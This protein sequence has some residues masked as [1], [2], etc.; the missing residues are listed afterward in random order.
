M[1]TLPKIPE[2]NH[3]AETLNR[4]LVETVCSM[5]I[6]SKLPHKFWAEALTT[7]AYLWNQSPTK[8]IEGISP[9]KAWTKEKPQ[10]EH[11]RAFGCNAYSHVPKDERQKLHSKVRKCIFWVTERKQKGI[12]C[13]TLTKAK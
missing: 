4:T 13:M 9:Y 1:S 2:Q 5:L 7:A 8:V 12:N 11:L 10:A 3:V 6:D